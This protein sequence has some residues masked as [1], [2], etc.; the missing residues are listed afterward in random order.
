MVIGLILTAQSIAAIDP[1]TVAGMWLFDDGS[2][3]IAQDSSGNGL[4]A[5]LIDGPQ[6]VNGKFGGALEFDGGGAHVVVPDHENPSVA[7]TVTAWVKSNTETWNQ[8]GWI[9]EKRDAYMM[10]PVADNTTVGWIFCN[11][12]CWNQPFTWDTGTV[13]PD[14]IT[15]WHMYTGTF[16][17]ATGEHKLYIDGNVESTLDLNKDPIVV[18]TGPLYIGNDT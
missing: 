7:I 16:D 4:D 9:V 12:S 15:Q 5:D 3:D 8:N 11:G 10:H 18:D 14:D 1:A 6:W 17:S 13:G 2:G